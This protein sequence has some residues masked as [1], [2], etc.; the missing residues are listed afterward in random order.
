MQPNQMGPGG[1]Q[2]T[3]NVDLS[4]ADDIL[5]Q[6]CGAPYFMEGM[7]LKRLSMLLSPTGKEEMINVQVLLCMKCGLEYGMEPTQEDA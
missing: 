3:V 4:K 2:Q 6:R 5:C 1:P 7:R